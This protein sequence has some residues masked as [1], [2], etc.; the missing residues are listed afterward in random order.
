MRYRSKRPM[1]PWTLTLFGLVPFIASALAMVYW[2]NDIA[3]AITAATWLLVYGAIILSFLGGVRW[4]VEIAQRERPRWG[5]LI[6]SVMGALTGWGLVLA[7]FRFGVTPALVAAMAG[8]LTVHYLWDRFSP[9]LP[10]WYR[11][12]RLWPTLGAVL[13]YGVAYLILR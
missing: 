11:A 5:D 12:L 9:D 4:G 2:R 1:A 7:G 13:S 8:A 6:V 10:R 3:L